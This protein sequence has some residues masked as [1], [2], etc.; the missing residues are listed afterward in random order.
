MSQSRPADDSREPL[1]AGAP[2]LVAY[3]NGPKPRMR[4]EPA[5]RWRTWMDETIGRNA[6]R[7]L[8]L[9]MANEAGWVLLNERRFRAEWPGGE[10]PSTLE[11]RYEGVKPASPAISIFGHGVLTFT[12]PYLFRTPP[13]W[14]LVVRGPT[15]SPRDGLTPLDGIVE[16]DWAVFP[17]TMNW[18]FTRPGA[19]EFEEDE[20]FCLVSP[21]Q[22]DQ[23]ERFEPDV[24]AAETDPE[25]KQAWEAA[26]QSRHDLSVKKFLGQ[27]AGDREA[28]NAWELDYFRGRAKDGR[29]ADGHITKRRL[30]PF[31][32]DQPV[33]E[34]AADHEPLDG[35]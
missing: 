14:D 2:Q 18:K 9:L 6:N 17:F 30:K 4:I 7:C 13:G 12:M 26:A 3:Y 29:R 27:F 16:T 32:A 33:D 25:L 15:N 1:A 31:G 8:P 19:V 22:R 34:P 20:P 24:R 23:L 5:S 35:A 21:M 10:G 28:L 11:V